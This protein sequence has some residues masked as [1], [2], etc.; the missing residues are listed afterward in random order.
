LARIAE[1]AAR[2][3]AMHRACIDAQAEAARAALNAAERDHAADFVAAIDRQV[4]TLGALGAAA[5]ANIVTAELGELALVARAHGAAFL[6]AGAGGGDVAYYVGL[7]PPPAALGEHARSLG[8]SR[9]ALRLG[10]R[11]VH[12]G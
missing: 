3:P 7:E 4:S 8:L 11:G 10:A 9:V 5:H 6:P 2:D 1:L 12:A